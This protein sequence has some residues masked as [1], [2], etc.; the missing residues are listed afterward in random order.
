MT[1]AGD[2]RGSG[3]GPGGGPDGDAVPAAPTGG[4]AVP[5][6]PTGETPTPRQI[7]RWRRYLANERA[8]GAV[9]RELARKKTGEERAILL[10]IADAEAR[11]EDYWRTR[12]GEYVGLPRK[13]SAGTRVMAWMAR[14]F[15]SVFVLALMQSAET[16]NDYIQDN[17]A[18]ERMAADEAIHAEVVRGL[19][20]RGRAQMSGN[21]RAAVFG[22]N[23]GLVSNLALVLGVIGSGVSSHVVLVT[24]VAGLLSGALSMAAGEYVS[25]SSQRELLAASTP[26]PEASEAVPKLDVDAN[27][28]ALVYRARGMEPEE[29]RVKAARVFADL[30]RHA[31]PAGAGGAPA[32]AVGEGSG[33]E[34]SRPAIFDAV[35]RQAREDIDAE[36]ATGSPVSAALSSFLCFAGGAVVPVLP[37]ILGLQGTAA[38]VLSCVL[39]SVA[40]M[41]TGGLVGLL[42]GMSPGR[43]ALRQWVIGMGAAAVTYGLGALFNVTTG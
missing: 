24:G 12:L 1:G 2:H 7:A 32:D 28:L 17:D 37:F 42:S 43:R 21:F 14:R 5:A 30:V 27:E 31:G 23:D 34:E 18:S 3:A 6:A 4:D 40:L 11:H 15:G 38:A 35:D 29:A 25:V 36:D 10:A 8:E 9:Y 41:L 19:A 33:G 16:R 13:A 20:S 22:A 39:V 26:D